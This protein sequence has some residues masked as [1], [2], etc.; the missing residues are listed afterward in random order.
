M[1]DPRRRASRAVPDG[2][3]ESAAAPL[4]RSMETLLLVLLVLMVPG[5]LTYLRS[6]L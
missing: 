5:L 2:V 1:C 6:N 4:R 3:P